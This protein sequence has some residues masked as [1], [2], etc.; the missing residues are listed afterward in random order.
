MKPNK[1][2]KDIKLNYTQVGALQSTDRAIDHT[3]IYYFAVTK[4]IPAN[5]V[6]R[7]DAGGMV[8]ETIT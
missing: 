3:P 2:L 6:V 1:K 4:A 7:W 8:I 5:T